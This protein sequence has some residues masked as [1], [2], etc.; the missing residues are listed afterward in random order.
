M[1]RLCSPVLHCIESTAPG[2]CFVTFP[3][4]QDKLR[5]L[6]V[7]EEAAGSSELVWVITS[8]VWPYFC[9]KVNLQFLMQKPISFMVEA[10]N[11]RVFLQ[12]KARRPIKTT[13]LTNA[14]CGALTSNECILWHS[15]CWNCH[16]GRTMRLSTVFFLTLLAPIS[17][18]LWN[19]L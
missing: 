10:V 13:M 11:R 15:K 2:L 17:G 5:G 4:L 14:V 16:M 6:T 7:T 9:L 12:E 3:W 18:I 19:T 1:F 8:L